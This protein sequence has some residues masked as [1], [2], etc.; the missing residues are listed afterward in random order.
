ML[1][2]DPILRSLARLAIHKGWL[3][4]A[5]EHRLRH[6]YIDAAG[7]MTD[8][9]MTDS[10]I[11]VVTGLQRRDIARLR[12]ETEPRQ[13]PRQPL[14]EIIARWW[15]DPNYDPEGIPILGAEGSFTSL[16]RSVRKDVHPRTFLDV[17]VEAGSVEERQDKV[18]L[19]TRSYQPRPGSDDQLAY[20][21]DNVGDHLS[22]SVSN[23]LGAGEHYDMAVHYTGLSAAGIR[24]L[25]TH[26]RERMKQLSYEI[27][28]MVRALPETADG[29]HR[30]RA[31]GYFFKDVDCEANSHDP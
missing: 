31:G 30:F 22:A 1:W 11:S 24:Q 14:A 3:F 20:L 4:P 12:K 28:T 2:L 9:V 23:V 10:R 26:Y 7:S 15:D 8:G 25:D 13:S 17:L 21:V 29:P 19:T 16:A 5:V 18:V 6:A 27:D